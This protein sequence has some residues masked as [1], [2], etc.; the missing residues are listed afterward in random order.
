[1]EDSTNMTWLQLFCEMRL[2]E[3]VVRYVHTLSRNPG[4]QCALGIGRR[5]DSRRV[6]PHK[7][8]MQRS[9]LMLPLPRHE[10][11]KTGSHRQQEDCVDAHG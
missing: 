10:S 8:T 11:Q 6:E 4:R 1:V 9:S 7:I 3:R 5:C 2:D